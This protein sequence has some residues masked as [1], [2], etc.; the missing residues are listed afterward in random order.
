MLSTIAG[1]HYCSISTM[2]MAL[3]YQGRISTVFGN[4][5]IDLASAPITPGQYTLELD[6]KAGNIT[7]YLPDYVQFTS[8]GKTFWGNRKTHQGLG[9]WKTTTKTFQNIFGLPSRTPEYAL[10]PVSQE[11]PVIIHLSIS[12]GMGDVKIY[13]L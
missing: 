3:L 8:D 9:V 13:R 10:A 6:T 4:I 7:V 2:G 12:T 11:Y 5:V 1:D